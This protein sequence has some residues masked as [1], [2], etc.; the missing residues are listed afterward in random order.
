MPTSRLVPGRYPAQGVSTI[1]DKIRERRGARGLTPLDGTLLHVPPVAE[2]WNTLL[3]AV[4]TKGQIP[5][6]VRELMILRVAARNHAAFEWIHH[7]HVGRD[8]GLNTSQLYLARDTSSLPPSTDS[9]LNALQSA[10]LAFADQST[11]QVRVE[12]STTAALVSALTT[13]ANGDKSK[14]EDLLVECS[15]ITASYN[16][17]SR[18]LVSLDVAA[19]RDNIVPWPATIQTHKIPIPYSNGHFIHVETHITHPSAPWLVLSNSLLTNTSMWNWA[20]PYML[21]PQPDGPA[22]VGVPKFLGKYNTYN[23][24]LHDQRGHGKSS[25]P[26]SASVDSPLP[27][28]IPLLASDISLLLS[29]LGIERAHAVIGV[30][31]GGA[32]ALAF[33]AMYPDKVDG[34]VS[35]DTGP[36]TPPGNKEAWAER[37]QLAKS[38]DDEKEGMKKLAGVTSPRWFGKGS[39]CSS[40]TE[41]DGVAAELEMRKT[42]TEV[43][44]EMIVN[45]P[46]EGFCVG[47]LALSDYDLLAGK[48][49]GD[50][51]GLLESNVTALLVAGSLDGAGKVAQG[52]TNLQTN[53]NT[54]RA[55]RGVK[56]VR[57]EIIEGA[58]HLPMVDETEKWWAAVGPWLSG[59]ETRGG[60]R[61]A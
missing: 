30:S 27:C 1:A 2:G 3:G 26:S 32:A 13:L 11:A 60:N 5:G 4:R 17:V 41:T 28:T 36:R 8:C 61:G 50:G 49:M 16:M 15:A 22:F 52:M 6:D 19:M 43:V 25:Y 35:C 57:L 55:E 34:I 48:D 53:W 7:E 31:Q 45:T 59:L 23:V 47:A 10:A 9:T 44:D 24:L 40:E 38:V 37:M 42:R 21:G 20:L 46:R 14:A 51:K 33:G 58:G 29:T 18:F 54:K 12:P 56:E 39:R